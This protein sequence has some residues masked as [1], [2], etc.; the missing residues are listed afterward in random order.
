MCKIISGG[1]FDV[2]KR[3]VTSTKL[4]EGDEIVSVV[5]LNE[6]QHIILQSK[7][8]Y[9]LRFDISEI[10]EVKKTAL[11]VHGMKMGDN[12][13][14]EQVFYTYAGQ[15]TKIEYKGKQIDHK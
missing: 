4:S 7:E 2:A 5:V 15:N 9:F 3:T 8:G 13:Y 14:I 12:D 11:G 6:Q 10:S 1:E